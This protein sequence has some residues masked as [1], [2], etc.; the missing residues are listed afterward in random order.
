MKQMKVEIPTG[1]P[2]QEIQD[3]LKL[4]LYMKIRAIGTWLEE[5]MG[6]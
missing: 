2:Y 6:S 3:T 1:D 5:M 4:Y